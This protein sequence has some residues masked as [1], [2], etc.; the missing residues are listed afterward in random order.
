MNEKY[1]EE[2]ARQFY[3]NHCKWWYKMTKK[4]KLKYILDNLNV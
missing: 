3:W 4:E 2:V 1:E